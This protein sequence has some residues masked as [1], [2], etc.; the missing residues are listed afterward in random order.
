MQK[1]VLYSLIILSVLVACSKDKFQTKPSVEIKSI[2]PSQV[3]AGVDL[4]IEL[5]FTDKEGDLD[6]IYIKKDRVNSIVVPVRASNAFAYQIPEFPEKSKGDIRIPINYELA[7][8]AAT[9]PRNQPEAPNGK[10]PD[11]LVFRFILKDKA[12]NFSDT[13]TSERIVVE[14]R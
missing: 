7:L 8:I 10:E 11:T 2:S 4:N 3:P 5:S 12:G 9:S 14:R 1:A 13:V 6:S